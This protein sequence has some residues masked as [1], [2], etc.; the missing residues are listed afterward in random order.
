MRVTTLLALALTLVSFTSL[1]AA[2]QA[3]PEG[4]KLGA[5]TGGEFK[6]A[7]VVI[8]NKCISCHSGQRIQEAIASGKDMLKIQKR[9]EQKGVKLSA[10]EKSALRIFWKDTPLRPKK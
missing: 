2:Q 5:V 10:D 3:P 1:H 8:D 7:H 4:S 9:M 6:E